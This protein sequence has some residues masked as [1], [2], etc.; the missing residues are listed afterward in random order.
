MGCIGVY[1]PSDISHLYDFAPY[2]AIICY[3][4][5]RSL[6]Y[7]C[8]TKVIL[9]TIHL[10]HAIHLPHIS[11]LPHTIYPSVG[12]GG[13]MVRTLGS[14]SR[15]PNFESSSCDFESWTIS[16]TPRCL[17]LQIT[18]YL[19]RFNKIPTQGKDPEDKWTR[20][21]LAYRESNKPPS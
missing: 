14:Q 9:H 10:S 19:T 7:R 12:R 21:P 5:T 20:K 11:H 1:S 16:F 8:P 17:K 6:D 3:H 13:I 15:E 18:Y 4:L 2:L